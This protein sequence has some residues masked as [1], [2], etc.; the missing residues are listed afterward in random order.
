MDVVFLNVEM[1]RCILRI[2]NCA[3]GWRQ[4]GYDVFLIQGG[5]TLWVKVPG[6]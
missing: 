4:L 1:M 3:P 6:A 5:R 2:W